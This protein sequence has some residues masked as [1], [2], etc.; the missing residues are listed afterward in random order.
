M[1]KHYKT[2][3]EGYSAPTKTTKII[4][5][6]QQHKL[7]QGIVLMPNNLNTAS[8]SCLVRIIRDQATLIAELRTR[9]EQL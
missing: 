4:K 2:G 9:G 3:G 7:A 5:D 8:R 6:Y 1:K